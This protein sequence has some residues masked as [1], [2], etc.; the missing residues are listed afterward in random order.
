MRGII[1]D[2]N[3]ISEPKRPSP[4][5]NVREWFVRQETDRYLTSTVI[6]ELAAGIARM[7]RWR[8]RGIRHSATE[9]R[10]PST[11]NTSATPLP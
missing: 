9:R 5:P 7:P 8:R 11:P 4:D 1:L 10:M 2:T 3:V 6:C